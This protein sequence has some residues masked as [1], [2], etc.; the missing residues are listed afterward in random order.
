[1]SDYDLVIIG[2]GPAGLCAAIEASEAGASVMIAEGDDAPGG[3]ARFAVGVVMGAGTRFQREAGITDDSAELLFQHYM[4]FNRWKVETACVRR[5]TSEAGGTIEWLADLGVPFAPHIIWSGDESRARG[6]LVVGEGQAL[7]D[8]LYGELTNRSKVDF[9]FRRRV[10]RILTDGARVTGVAVGGDEVSSDAVVVAAGGF[11]QN[12]ELLARFYPSGL[13]AGGDWSYP[14]HPPTAQGDAIR[15]AEQLGAQIIGHDR[16]L[17]SIRPNFN[18]DLGSG[19][20]PGWLMVVNGEGRRFYDEMA[21]YSVTYPIVMGQ[22]G[23]IYAILD[24]A[25]K[26]LAQPQFARD[27]KKVALPGV[28][29]E[30]WVEPVIDDMVAQGIVLKADT[31]E[32]LAQ[33]MGVPEQNLRG[34]FARYN[35]DVAEGR[36][37]FYLKN[38]EFLRPV[39]TPP[40][41]A[42][43]LRLALLAGTHCGMR[44]DDQAR[45]INHESH[46]IPGLYAAGDATGGV[47]GEVYLGSGNSL[48]NSTTFGR[49]AGRSAAAEALS[50]R[51]AAHVG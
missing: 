17:C 26:Q 33:R 22:P 42:T 5:L 11:A 2:S 15:F 14:V 23:P 7:V 9:A 19:Y 41:Y 21:P 35:A 28:T 32:E 1:M 18:R 34:T 49:A 40:F 44:I 36:D 39:A 48:A 20:F 8:A 46:P 6:H 12:P 50:R 24:D 51:S 43:E 31:V 16:G 45:V 27:A 10:D 37:S 25:T 47:I 29:A 13:A 30:D 4:A 38:P 3:G